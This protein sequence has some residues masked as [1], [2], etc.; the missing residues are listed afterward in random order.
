MRSVCLA[1]CSPHIACDV[2]GGMYFGARDID[3]PA[4]TLFGCDTANA[5]SHAV[6]AM[7]SMQRY[8]LQCCATIHYRTMNHGTL[9]ATLVAP[10]PTNDDACLLESVYLNRQVFASVSLPVPHGTWRRP[11][12]HLPCSQHC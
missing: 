6:H 10:C 12:L 8:V 11:T 5:L 3:Y 4:A 1:M 2:A 7:L 9:H